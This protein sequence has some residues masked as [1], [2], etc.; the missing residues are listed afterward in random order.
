MIFKKITH[1]EARNLGLRL[2]LRERCDIDKK[3]YILAGFDFMRRTYLLASNPVSA[4]AHIAK[5]QLR[6][7]YYRALWRLYDLG[8]AVEISE[9]SPIRL[10]DL[11]LR[12][13]RSVL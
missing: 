13:R 6:E 4:E 1:L 12:R 10:R 7:L 3:S 2:R 5:E 8:F 9:S 11:R